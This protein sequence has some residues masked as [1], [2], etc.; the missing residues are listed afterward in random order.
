MVSH[1]A[2]HSYSTGA[3]GHDTPREIQWHEVFNSLIPSCQKSTPLRAH[4][5]N[6]TFCF[7]TVFLTKISTSCSYVIIKIN[8]ILLPTCKHCYWSHLQTRQNLQ[9]IVICGR[10]GCFHLNPGFEPVLMEAYRALSAALLKIK[11]WSPSICRI[12]MNVFIFKEVLSPA[13]LM[14]L[15]TCWLKSC[16][17]HRRIVYDSASYEEHSTSNI[18]LLPSMK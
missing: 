4:T 1:G 17:R 14:K 3:F 8:D 5:Q 15:K 9:I 10:S 12:A 13:A 7:N 2:A 11:A 16:M 6:F 18:C